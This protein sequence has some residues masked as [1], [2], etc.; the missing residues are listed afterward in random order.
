MISSQ[1]HTWGHTEIEIQD[2]AEDYTL[3]QAV[4]ALHKENKVNVAGNLKVYLYIWGAVTKDLIC[5]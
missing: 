3:V 4:L 5:G 1:D 2:R